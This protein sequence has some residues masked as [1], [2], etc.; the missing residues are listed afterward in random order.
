MGGQPGKKIKRKKMG[1]ENEF[2]F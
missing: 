2:N 1:R